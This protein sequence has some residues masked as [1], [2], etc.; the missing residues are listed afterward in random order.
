M[1]KLTWTKVI[2]NLCACV[3]SYLPKT[4]DRIDQAEHAVLHKQLKSL[5]IISNQGQYNNFDLNV[6][7]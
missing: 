7:T 1:V 6:C 5:L 2:S 4:T 3:V